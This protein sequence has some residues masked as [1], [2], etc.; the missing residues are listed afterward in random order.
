MD[1]RN[2]TPAE[3]RAA[4]E[5][6]GP[7]P[8]SLWTILRGRTVDPLVRWTSI[9][10]QH[11]DVA[12]YRFAFRDTFFLTSADGAKRVL[13]DNAPN[14]TKQHSSYRMLRRLLGDGLLTSE[15][16]FWLRQRRL[17]QPSFQRERIAAMAG[18]MVSSALETGEAWE[19][20]A[21]SGA[22]LSLAR[23]MSALT[24][25]IVGE[26]LFG[27]T[28]AAQTAA[29]AASWGVLNAQLSER[30]R[31]FRLLPPILPTPYDAAFRRARRTLFDVVDEII[32]AKR[33]RGIRGADLL[34]AWMHARDEDTGERM[35]DR[36]LRDEVVTMLLAGHE[37]TAI[38]LTWAWIR[39]ALDRTAARLLHDEL[40]RV[41][42][43]RAPT[44]DDV[45]RLP[46]TKALVNETLRFHSPAYIV[47]RHVLDDDVIA[48]H[49]IHRGGSI[50]LSPLVL[51]RHPA[52]WSH[53]DTFDPGRWLER[54][55]PPRPKFA[56][57]PFSAGPRQCIGNHFSLME[58][59]LILAV[60][61]QRFAPRLLDERLPNTE[62]L[63]LARPVGPVSARIER[64]LPT[65][66]RRAPS[67]AAG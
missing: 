27:A 51:H 45:G 12:R 15:G 57:I 42:G 19:R 16:D 41:L 1:A 22:P 30:V 39:L 32:R 6:S 9:R 28:L 21:S 63:V 23:E 49:R 59:V 5:P 8:V 44:A 26:A 4:R 11:G 34:T 58:S 43:G 61:A 3:F 64:R 65:N 47:N 46:Y 50:V 24:L 10:E 25:R 31:T 36:Q 54:E 62:Y 2:A 33:S 67:A 29:I 52:Y 40:D 60:L 18:A 13:Q 20:A 37:T 14:Y 53:P 66:D 35:T 56:F 55:D 17:A 38:T 48:G 7:P